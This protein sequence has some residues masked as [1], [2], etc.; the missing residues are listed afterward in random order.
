MAVEGEE[1]GPEAP[2]EA[3]ASGEAVA[4]APEEVGAEAGW[5]HLVHSDQT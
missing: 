5:D 3:A 4:A 2:E 1:G